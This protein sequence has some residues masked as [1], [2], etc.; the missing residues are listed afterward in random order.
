MLYV[1]EGLANIEGVL[2]ARPY[3]YLAVEDV[4]WRIF[5]ELQVPHESYAVRIMWDVG[6]GVVGH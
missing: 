4:V 2:L 1:I 5:L 6:V 3:T